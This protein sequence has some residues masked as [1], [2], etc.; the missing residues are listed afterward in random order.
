VGFANKILY[1][2]GP[3]SNHGP[4]PPQAEKETTYTVVW[5]ITNT[6]NNISKTKITSSLPPWVRFVGPVAP[7]SEDL[8]YNPST[9]EIVW[10]VGNL[11]RGTG[12]T[13]MER[14]V[15]FQIAFTPSIS[16]VGSLPALINDAVLTGHDDFA[17]VSVRVNKYSLSTQ[18]PNDPSLP[19]GGGRVA[20]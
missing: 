10:N 9:K 14:E 5:N 6:S 7:A 4:I 2:S 19:P 13:E 20:E 18:L 11:K 12:I 3:F 16:Q 15:A 1:Y 8:T 17:N